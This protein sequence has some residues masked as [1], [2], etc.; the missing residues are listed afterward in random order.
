MKP[1]KIKAILFDSGRVLNHP[2]TGHWFIPPNFFKYVDKD[3]YDQIE[4]HVLQKAF[5]SS[6]KLIDEQVF[7]LTEQE[8]FQHFIHF[9]K[10]F[11]EQLPELK[12]TDTQIQSIAR[13]TVFNDE[14]FYFHDDVFDVIPKLS[15]SYQL[16][17]VS[18]TWPSLERVFKNIHLRHYFSTFIMSSMI[19]VRKPDQLMFTNALKELKVDPDETIFIDDSIK[20][21]EGARELGIHTVWLLRDRNEAR[22][23]DYVSI[24]DLYQFMTILERQF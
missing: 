5:Q 23:G 16:G 8:E 18:D 21:L 14:K 22:D 10:L 4:P 17:V 9:Y 3:K 11:S 2:R 19:G 24:H 15:E 6:L 7:I 20:N 1:K 13:D 12:L